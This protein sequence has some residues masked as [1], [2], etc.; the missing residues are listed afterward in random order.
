M[1]I[2]NHNYNQRYSPFETTILMKAID[3]S[4]DAIGSYYNSTANEIE[5]PFRKSI[6]EE[7]D[8]QME[9]L[10]NIK[11]WLNESAGKVISLSENDAP[12]INDRLKSA[13]ELYLRGLER[14]IRISDSDQLQQ[15]KG[16]INKIMDEEKFKDRSNSLYLKYKTDPLDGINDKEIFISYSHKDKHTAGKL[17]ILLKAKGFETFL[18]HDDLEINEVWRN[19]IQKHLDSCGGL[20][21]VVTDNFLGSCWTHQECGYVMGVKK[22][23][24]SLFYSRGNSGVLE[25]R[26][27]ISMSDKTLDQAIEELITAF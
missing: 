25:S 24:A 9:E 19:E 13:L 1:P 18:A 10:E 16:I 6:Y 20:V 14:S 4:R 11:T 15:E 7:R 26:Q 21:A 2:M 12:F 22:P 27:G 17:S 23:I 3:Y 5:A 8:K